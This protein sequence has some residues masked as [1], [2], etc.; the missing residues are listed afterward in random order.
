M[1]KEILLE[2]LDMGEDCEFE[3]KASQEKLPKDIWET[4]SAFA[5]SNGG[6]IALGITEKRECFEITGVKKVS[7]Q[8]KDFWNSH[9]NRQ[10]LSYPICKESNIDVIE[11]E[12][13][14]IIIIKVPQAD[15]TQRPI[16]INNN[17]M[18]GTYKRNNDGDYLCQE[19]EVR[20]MLRDASNEP[21]DYQI[22]DNFTLKDLDSETIRAFRQRFSIR[23][24]GC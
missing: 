24:F 23:K 4:I 7:Q 13:K 1:D 9:N 18:M 21:Q 16:Y 17:P 15:R 19:Y 12:G 3:C 14:Q 20:Q 2:K 11:I 8:K 5:N 10:K 22:I 6:N